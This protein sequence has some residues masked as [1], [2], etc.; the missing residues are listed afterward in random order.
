[1]RKNKK[2]TVVCPTPSPKIST[3]IEVRE[4]D[5]NQVA[6]TSGGK[7]ERRTFNPATNQA[8]T[9]RQSDRFRNDCFSA[10]RKQIH[11]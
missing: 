8:L 9:M 11:V 5:L 4:L 2:Q 3:S 7:G 1:M 10:E 6:L